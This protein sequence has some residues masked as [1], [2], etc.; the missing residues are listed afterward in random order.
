MRDSAT[1]ANCEGAEIISTTS[2][3]INGH[4]ITLETF[5]CPDLA[6]A[7]SEKRS[8]VDSIVGRSASECND[9]EECAC[10]EARKS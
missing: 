7:T 10:G 9:P 3:E 2:Y 4:T 1:S 5:T 8:L 6:P